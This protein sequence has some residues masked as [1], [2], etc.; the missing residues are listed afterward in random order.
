MLVAPRFLEVFGVAPAL[1][2]DFAPAE[3]HFGGPNAVLISRP[4]LAAPL[5]R[6]SERDRK[7]PSSGKLLLHRHWR[8]AGLLSF[9]SDPMSICFCPVRW[10]RRMRR[11]EAPPGSTSLDGSSPVFRSPPPKR[12][13]PTVQAQLGRQFPK[14][15]GTLGVDV[16]PL[17]G[18]HRWRRSP[19]SLDSLRLRLPAAPD[20][21]HQYRRAAARPHRRARTRN[22]GPLLSGRNTRFG[23][24]PNADRMPGP[25]A[26]RR[27]GRAG[28]RSGLASHALSRSGERPSAGS[29]DR[30]DWR[31][32]LYTL[33]CALAAT[34][35][36]GL[37]PAI[38]ASRRNISGDL[39]RAAAHHGLHA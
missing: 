33:A 22:L 25:G 9:S 18:D 2:R 27:C 26:R 37:F 20:R 17:K 6:R 12:T 31:I 36:C 24:R 38:R 10:T 1:G 14:T 29:G 4:F 19:F 30:L 21:L 7:T 34:L 11:I 3:E 16:N 13:S 32:V 8:H 39:S 28:C 23:D 5:Q 15:D 35:L